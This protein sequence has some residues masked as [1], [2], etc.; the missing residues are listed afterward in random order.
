[1]TPWNGWR[2]I[3][4]DGH[5]RFELATRIL[6]HVH[7]GLEFLK[8]RLLD[9]KLSSVIRRTYRKLWRPS[10]SD[11]TCICRRQPAYRQDNPPGLGCLSPQDRELCRISSRILLKPPTSTEFWQDRINMVRH[12]LDALETPGPWDGYPCRWRG[13]QTGRISA[14]PWCHAGLPAEYAAHISKIVSACYYH[15]RRTPQLRH[16]LDKD[17]R[18]RLVS[19]LVLSRIDY[20][21]VALARLPAISLVPLQRVINAA[22]RFVANFRPREHVSHVLRDLH[23]LPISERISYK[24]CLM[25]F[26]VVNGTAPTYI[27]GLVTRIPD[28][29][30][31]CHLRSAAEGLFDVPRNQTVFGSRAFSIAGPLAWNGLPAHVRAIRDVIPFKSALKTFFQLAYVSSLFYHF[32]Y[33]SVKCQIRLFNSYWIWWTFQNYWTLFHLFIRCMAPLVDL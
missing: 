31:R 29:P 4:R 27:T 11:T 12:A 21:N 28:L 14:K 7:W 33:I 20:C 25:M 16:C 10:R 17:D 24:V 5:K 3:W 13:G 8:D 26:N 1:M 15:F 22:A 6:I 23:W 30:G 19:A 2:L 18:Q 9:L 32:V